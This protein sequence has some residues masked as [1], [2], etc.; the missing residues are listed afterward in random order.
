MFITFTFTPKQT[1]I[2][3]PAFVSRM[4]TGRQTDTEVGR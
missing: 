4:Q 2:N 3:L 1:R